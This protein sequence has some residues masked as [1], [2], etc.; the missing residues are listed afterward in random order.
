MRGMSGRLKPL[1]AG[2]IWQ[3]DLGAL[4]PAVQWTEIR[5]T[6]ARCCQ[7][8]AT[9]LREQESQGGAEP[10]AQAAGPEGGTGSSDTAR[11]GAS[12]GAL[13]PAH[14]P[15]RSFGGAAKSAGV[16]E[17]EVAGRAATKGDQPARTRAPLWHQRTAVFELPTS[18][19]MA[20]R[21]YSSASAG[22]SAA[23]SAAEPSVPQQRLFREKP[24]SLAVDVAEGELPIDERPPPGVYGLLLRLLGYYSKEARLIRASRNLYAQV[25][26]RAE[27]ERFT[28]A[29]GLPT[30]FRATY[31]LLVL[32]VWLCLVR[33]RAEGR[34][35]AEVGQ[36]LYDLFFHDCELRVVATGVKVLISKWTTELEKNFYGAAAAYDGAMQP[37]APPDALAQALWRNVFA[38]DGSEMPTGAAAAPVQALARYVRRETASLS[39]TE[40]DAF[41][42][43]SIKF[44]H[45]F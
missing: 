26:A 39:M 35:G 18:A 11:W 8:A 20:V 25:T 21:A 14:I 29:L 42:R 44:S 43:G 17:H 36:A 30:S 33:L 37:A 12:G 4:W 7:L 38:E 9:S 45:D 19:T 16:L 34:D 2:T 27:D 31:S 1:A 41:M 40:S 6:A 28:H 10:S 23:P 13:F 24:R 3:L 32:H 15:D 5:S 22:P